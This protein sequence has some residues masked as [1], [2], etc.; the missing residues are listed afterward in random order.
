MLR[1]ISS[2][3]LQDRSGVGGDTGPELSTFLSD[4]S[5]DSRSFHFTLVVDDNSSTV[6]EVN[7]D[8]LLSAERLSLAND[9]GGKDLLS[10]F[11]LSLLY[12]AHDHIT[13]SGLGQTIQSSSNITDSD[14]SKILGT[15]VVS[16]VDNSGNWETSGHS[17]L[18]TRSGGSSSDS[19]LTHD[20]LYIDLYTVTDR[21]NVRE[22]LQ[23]E[24]A[25]RVLRYCRSSRIKSGVLFS[26]PRKMMFGGRS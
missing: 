8:S 17:V 14:K 5:R 2:I 7:K 13:R 25:S 12:R 19:F 22:R 6:L 3:H 9:N 1:I 10:E 4:G 18:D 11:R 21:T 26:T 15:R 24:F 16:A 20:V 23:N